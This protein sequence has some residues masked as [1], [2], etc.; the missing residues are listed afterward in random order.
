MEGDSYMSG[1]FPFHRPVLVGM[2]PTSASIIGGSSDCLGRVPVYLCEY[3]CVCSLREKER[4]EGDEGRAMCMG[5][6]H[7]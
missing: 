5:P 4:G 3:V 1:T 6:S 7:I 2:V